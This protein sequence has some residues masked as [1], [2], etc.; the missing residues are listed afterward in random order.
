MNVKTLIQIFLIF[1][2]LLITLFFFYKYFYQ[3]SNQSQ[4]EQNEI[5]IEKSPLKENVNNVIEDLSFENIDMNG[6]KFKIDSKFGEISVDE[7]NSV[8]LIDVKAEIKIVGKDT[9]FITSK[10]ADYNK[11]NLKTKFYV[12]V[13]IFYQENLIT[14]ENFYIDLSKN[15][16]SINGNIVFNNKNMESY[17]DIIDFN[18]LDESITINMF[19]KEDRIKIK[20]K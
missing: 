3:T 4:L 15:F 8:K 12:D 1:T 17:A 7:E 13:N 5:I 16:A 19:D 9:I 10:K 18:I 14:S 6:N 2:I 20:R 11:V